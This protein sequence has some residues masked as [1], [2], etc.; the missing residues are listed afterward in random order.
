M[1]LVSA[2]FDRT[3]GHLLT[4]KEVPSC[5]NFQCNLS[6]LSLFMLLEQRI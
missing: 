2:D 1:I 5:I 3:I 6:W 4:C